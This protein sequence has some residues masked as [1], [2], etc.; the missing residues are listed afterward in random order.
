MDDRLFRT[1]MSKFATG[2]TVI[3][4]E[5]DGAYHGMT[6]NAFMS[7]SLNPQLILVSIA[8]KAKFKP[9]VDQTGTFAVS[10]LAKGQED[11]SMHFA[12]QI[13]K[14]EGFTF[15]SF[16]GMPVIDGAIATIACD[17]HNTSVQGD[18][19]LYIGRVRDIAVADGDP[20]AYFSGKYY[21]IQLADGN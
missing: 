15:A 1:A 6:A 17:V 14:E 2:V 12:G 5:V 8:N 19:T 9:M 10:L 3:S 13:K 11:I 18:H 4:T 7:V 20:L 16:D 21:D